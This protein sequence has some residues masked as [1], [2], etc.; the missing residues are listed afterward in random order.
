M[1]GY[2]SA[3]I[4]HLIN[5]G[6][7]DSSFEFCSPTTNRL[8]TACLLRGAIRLGPLRLR[9]SVSVSLPLIEACVQT[10]KSLFSCT[11]TIA[12]VI[13]ALYFGY[14]LSLRPDDYLYP[15]VNNFHWIRRLNI[16]S[17]F[18]GMIKPIRVSDSILFPPK[19]TRPLRLSILPDSDKANP[20]AR[21][22]MCA[23]ACDPDRSSF[24]FITYLLDFFREFPSVGPYNAIFAGIPDNIDLY[25]SV[26]Q[27]MEVTAPKLGIKIS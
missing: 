8:L 12:A 21:I 1:S 3:V 23:C 26:R 17:W 24:C 5:R 6:I 25:T 2:V 14:A 13:A 20:L 16:V 11:I 18:V 7:I 9:I 27:T 15:I 19:G 10:A 22:G 4:F